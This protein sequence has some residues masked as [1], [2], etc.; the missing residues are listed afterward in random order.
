MP[1]SKALA[2]RGS[3]LTRILAAD[4]D[5]HL[6]RIQAATLITSLPLTGFDVAGGRCLPGGVRAQSAWSARRVESVRQLT[7]LRG[8][9]STPDMPIPA[10]TVPVLAADGSTDGLRL[11]P[12]DAALGLSARDP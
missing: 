2:S 1:A 8:N 10:G 6:D 3:S 4:P 11:E 12:F 9:R 5:T 7:V